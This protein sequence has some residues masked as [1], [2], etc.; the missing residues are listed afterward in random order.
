MR[1]FWTSEMWLFDFIL[2]A[3]SEKAILFI[4]ILGLNSLPKTSSGVFV[5][6]THLHYLHPV[7]L[8]FTMYLG[9]VWSNNKHTL[10]TLHVFKN[11]YL[12]QLS[13]PYVKLLHSQLY[14]QLCHHLVSVLIINTNYWVYNSQFSNCVYIKDFKTNVK[15]IAYSDLEILQANQYYIYQ[16]YTSPWPIRLVILR[17]IPLYQ[18]KISKTISNSTLQIHITGQLAS[19][20]ILIGNTQN[21]TEPLLSYR[22]RYLLN[23]SR[24]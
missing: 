5:L 6:I 9:P 12:T 3:A 23:V 22:T 11:L 16:T 20:M 8:G 24:N 19:Q 13:N 18:N 10:Y 17:V 1:D 15:L 7:L 4:A 14:F 21:L 2:K